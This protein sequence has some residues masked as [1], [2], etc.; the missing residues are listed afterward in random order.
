MSTIL[1]DIATGEGQYIE[2]KRLI[3]NAESLA[4]EVIAFANSDGGTLFVGVD[5]DGSIV[6]LDNVESVF[7]SL[8]NICRERCIPPISPVIEQHTINNSEIIVLRVKSEFNH[9]KPYRTAGGRFFIRIG[10]DKKDATGRELI[11][12]AQAA[13]ELHY[14]ES[15]VLGAALDQLSHTAFAHYHHLQFGLSVDEHL[16][17]SGLKLPTLLRNLRLGLE[18][19]GEFVLTVTGLLVFGDSPQRFMPQSRISAVAFAGVNED[20]DILDRRE[21]KGRLPD[22]IK[23]ARLFL[24]RNIRLPAREH[25]FNRED[26]VLY[27]RKALGEAVVNAVAHRDY[28]LSGSQ[29][30]LFVFKDRIE[31]RS[32]GRLPNSV[33]LDNIKLGVHV[34]RN[35]TIATLLT[36][37][38]T[39]SAIGTGIPRLI[40]RLTRELSGR[41]PE[42]EVVGDELRVRI[43]ARR[44][45]VSNK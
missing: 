42:F 9:L 21:I 23:D 34:E 15:P 19:E 31:V 32:P 28:S 7:Q 2:F 38:G 45:E 12:I 18:L 30:R 13:G 6:G 10:K 11:R 16:T 41:E 36:Q 17:Q 40:I 20:A 25:G 14:D 29:I 24:E 35:R 4:G 44:V 22:L 37:L 3:D 8:T 39:M 5:D 26:I 43:W 1:N 27:D 33:T